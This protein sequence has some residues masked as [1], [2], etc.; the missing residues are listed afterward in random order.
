MKTDMHPDYSAYKAREYFTLKN[1]K[2]RPLDGKDRCGFI[3]SIFISTVQ[4]QADFIQA[5]L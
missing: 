4:S 5:E 2:G 3:Y 1:Q